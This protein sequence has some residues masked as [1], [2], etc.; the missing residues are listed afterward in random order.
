V[1]NGSGG[2]RLA[3]TAAITCGDQAEHGPAPAAAA[4]WNVSA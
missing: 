3:T 1:P 4:C 2:L